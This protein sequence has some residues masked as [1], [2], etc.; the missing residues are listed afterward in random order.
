MAL[1]LSWPEDKPCQ[2]TLPLTSSFRWKG[3][4]DERRQGELDDA[5][6]FYREL[7]QIIPSFPRGHM[8]RWDATFSWLDSRAEECRSMAAVV[9]DQ[10]CRAKLLRLA[11]TYQRAAELRTAA[12]R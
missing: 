3:E 2:R 7:A 6:R 4:R 9:R 12:A 5:A 11:Q 10:E 8:A 1:D